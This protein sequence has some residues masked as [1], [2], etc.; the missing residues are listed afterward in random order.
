MIPVSW[1]DHID[2]D[3]VHLILTKD[4]AKAQRREKH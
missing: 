3:G 1:G 4:D 2:D